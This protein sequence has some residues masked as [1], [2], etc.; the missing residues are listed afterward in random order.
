MAGIHALDKEELDGHG[1]AEHQ[2]SGLN[3]SRN[4]IIIICTAFSKDRLRFKRKIT[5][6]DE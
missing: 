3:Y 5:V 6:R 1:S 2:V 4:G